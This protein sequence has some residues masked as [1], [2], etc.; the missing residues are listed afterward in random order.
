M[1][2]QC[3]SFDGASLPASFVLIFVLLMLLRY[4]FYE[5]HKIV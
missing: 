2:F 1:V 4:L 5:I 3:L